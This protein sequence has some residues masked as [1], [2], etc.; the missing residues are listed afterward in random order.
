MEKGRNQKDRAVFEARM[1]GAMLLKNHWDDHWETWKEACEY[2]R[3]NPPKVEGEFPEEEFSAWLKD[4][5]DKLDPDG[6]PIEPSA[7]EAARWMHDWLHDH[8]SQPSRQREDEVRRLRDALEFYAD[9]SH[10]CAGATYDGEADDGYIDRDKGCRARL[11]L[12]TPQPAPD[13]RKV[14]ARD[15]EVRKLA[16]VA[17]HNWAGMT[18]EDYFAT[19]GKKRRPWEDLEQWEHDEIIGTVQAVLDAQAPT[20]PTKVEGEF[21]ESQALVPLAEKGG[22]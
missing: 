11:A 14:D 1:E 2:V 22:S 20:E 21:P 8:M 6:Y 12:G 5:G 13:E 9:E 16:K 15:S 10:Y 17:H 7:Y 3:A 18:D 19:T 4:C